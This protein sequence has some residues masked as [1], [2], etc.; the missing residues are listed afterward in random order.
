MNVFFPAASN[1]SQEQALIPVFVLYSLTIR[2]AILFLFL[3]VSR[4]ALKGLHY[5]FLHKELREERAVIPPRVQKGGSTVVKREEK[6]NFGN[7]YS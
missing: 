1:A 3:E 5:V 7:K 6:M 2:R 4:F